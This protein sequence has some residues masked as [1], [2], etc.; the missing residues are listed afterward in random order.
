MAEKEAWTRVLVVN[1]EFFK[2]IRSVRSVTA[3]PTA[4][5]MIYGSFRATDL[6]AEYDRHHY[7]QHPKIASTLAL[8]SMEREGKALS[9]AAAEIKVER[10]RVDRLEHRIEQAEGAMKTLK[11]KNPSLQ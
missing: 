9:A 6:V 3:T 11:Q 10:E 5:S 2:D 7:I 4:A 8:T 1:I